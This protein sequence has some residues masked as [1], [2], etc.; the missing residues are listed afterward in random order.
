[1][2]VEGCTCTIFSNLPF[3]WGK[4]SKISQFFLWTSKTS[5]SRQV[6]VFFSKL[7]PSV[8]PTNLIHAS[9]I[10]YLSTL[11]TSLF[12]QKDF[13]FLVPV[14]AVGWVLC[15]VD[16]ELFTEKTKHGV[17][18]KH[19]QPAPASGNTWGRKAETI[20]LRGIM[21]FGIFVNVNPIVI[22][23]FFLANPNVDLLWRSWVGH[24]V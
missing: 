23:S 11:D 8:I 4:N 12:W 6:V 20:G 7:E 18:K 2:C 21:V 1:M 15:T 5:L 19:Q 24:L 22:S 9:M 13:T 16:E 10:P 3:I 17:W 14:V